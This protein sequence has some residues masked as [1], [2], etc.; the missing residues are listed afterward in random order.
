MLFSLFINN[1]AQIGLISLII[2]VF[3][4]Q[5]G[6]FWPYTANNFPQ[7][8]RKNKDCY[9]IAASIFHKLIRLNLLVYQRFLPSLC[10]FL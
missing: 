4:P 9:M 2:D 3:L 8:G 6:G 7:V 5:I 1:F 10:L